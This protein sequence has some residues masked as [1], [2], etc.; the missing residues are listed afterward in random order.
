MRV[1]LA[2]TV[3]AMFACRDSFAGQSHAADAAVEGRVTDS[4]DA[5]V[6]NA[7][8]IVSN[9]GT[10]LWRDAH[11]DQAGR[12][13]IQWLTPGSYSVRIIREPFTS[14]RRSGLKLASGAVAVVNAR[15][16]D[17]SVNETVTVSAATT[18][19][20]RLEQHSAQPREHHTER[21]Y[22]GDV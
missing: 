4:S 1:V 14:D 20:H 10:G 9:D 16:A 8:V 2:A 11:T 6:L 13:R 17:G 5:A 12:Y 7:L 22:T 18:N 19:R 21:N 15:L 3:T